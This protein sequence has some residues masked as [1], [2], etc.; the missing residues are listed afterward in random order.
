MELP[1]LLFLGLGAAVAGMW[2]WSV[3]RTLRIERDWR[4]PRPPSAPV[5]HAAGDVTGTDTDSLDSG[6]DIGGGDS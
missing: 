5:H 3:A 1:K 4:R 2:I 6:Y